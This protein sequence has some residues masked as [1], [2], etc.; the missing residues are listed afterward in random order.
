MSSEV[1]AKWMNSL[2]LLTSEL[3]SNLSFSQYSNAFTSWLVRA[4]MALT[5]AASLSL[6]FAMA[7]SN[8]LMVAG[9]NAAISL[10][11][12]AAA[13]AL[14]HSTSTHARCLISAYSLK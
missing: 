4:S 6:K 1:Q 9:L 3:A 11:S 12:L 10:N 14:S 13:S 2:A 7:A 5:W 8:S